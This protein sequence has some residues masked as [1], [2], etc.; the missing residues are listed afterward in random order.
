M[1]YQHIRCSIYLYTRV[2]IWLKQK[3][4]TRIV[5]IL[6]FKNKKQLSIDDDIIIINSPRKREVDIN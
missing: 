4:Q 6:I 3:K 2:L 1:K 5:F